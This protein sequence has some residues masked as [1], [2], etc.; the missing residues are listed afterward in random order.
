MQRGVYHSSNEHMC[1]RLYM[2]DH[3]RDA[4]HILP[5][6]SKRLEIAGDNVDNVQ[7]DCTMISVPAGNAME[8]V[9]PQ[10]SSL[11]EIADV[12]YDLPRITAA[13]EV[14]QAITHTSVDWVRIVA[15]YCEPDQPGQLV[16]RDR[17]ATPFF[18]QKDSTVTQPCCR[19]VHEHERTAR[20]LEFNL[21]A[22]M[23][24][25]TLPVHVLG[26][27]DTRMTVH[28]PPDTALT[29]KLRTLPRSEHTQDLD[30]GPYMFIGDDSRAACISY[31]C[32]SLMRS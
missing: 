22:A 23:Q 14:L 9:F 24:P 12:V 18:A 19:A 32:M 31:D 27:W 5:P 8:L 13:R 10:S 7:T 1:Q 4:R 26:S 21:H 20:I 6:D 3:T 28:T 11:A 30:Q 2:Y 29:I 25:L 17:A 16:L 15:A